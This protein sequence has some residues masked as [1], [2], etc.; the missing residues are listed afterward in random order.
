MANTIYNYAKSGLLSGTFNLGSDT[1]KVALVTSS[2][3]PNIDTNHFFSDLSN[4]VSGTGYTAGG[5]TLTSLAVS[6]DTTNDRGAFDAAD[7]TWSTSTI[8]ARGAVVYKSTGTSSTSPLLC[9]F[10]FTTDQISSAGNFTITWNA[11]GLLLLS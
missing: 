10:D 4:E 3:T 5:A 9:Y 7:V 1:L 6:T 2:Y 11:N 8:T